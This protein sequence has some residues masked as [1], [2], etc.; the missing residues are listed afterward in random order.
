[1]KQYEPCRI[2]ITV[3]NVQDVVRTS[4]QKVALDHFDDTWWTEI[5]GEA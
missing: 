5:G 3:L 1:M 2:K 4:A